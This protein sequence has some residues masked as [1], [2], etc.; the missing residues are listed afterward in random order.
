MRGKPA[1]LIQSSV[2]ISQCFS[3]AD[4]AK[5]TFSTLTNCTTTISSSCEVAEGIFNQTNLDL[6]AEK[7]EAVK[8]KSKECY[9]LVTAQ[10]SPVSQENNKTVSRRELSDITAGPVRR[11]LLLRHR[12]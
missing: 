6:C 12:C 5:E 8:T 11:L 9:S 1:E 2:N 10:P 3:V 4:S 7:F